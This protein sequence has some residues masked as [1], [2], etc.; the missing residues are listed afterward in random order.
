MSDIPLAIGID[1][2]GTTVKTGVLYRSNVI[3]AAEPIDTQEFSE[4]GPLIQ[5]IAEVVAD[6]RSRHPN[7]AAIGVGMPGFVDFKTG[8]VH[9]LT[10]VKGWTRIPLKNRLEEL[11]ELPVTVENDANCMAYAEWKR[12]SGRGLKHMVALTLGTGVGGGLIVNGE[13]VRGA[14]SVAGEIGQ[15]S[16]HFEGRRG[17]WGNLGALEDYIGNREIAARAIEA[18]AEAGTPKKEEECT[19]EKLA[20]AAVYHDEIA[21]KIWDAVAKK[22]ATAIMNCCW[23]LNPQA[24]I[25][26][27]GV[28]KAGSTLF[29]PLDQHLRA[30]LSDPFKE[31]L[32]I[33]PARFG[34]EAGIIGAATLAL[35]QAGHN[36]DDQ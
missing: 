4:A 28:A 34:N 6:L 33:L 9:A 2:G 20:K 21:L 26:G 8:L 5:K 17:A 29:A 32:R 30:Q 16:I 3:E 10:N 14:D 31:N 23:L 11:T 27:G 12:G 18:Y 25:I 13:M 19:P 1:F 36:V 15:T 22:L 35:E 24:I 7:I